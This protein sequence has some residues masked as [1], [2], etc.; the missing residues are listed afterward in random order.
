MAATKMPK[1]PGFLVTFAYYFLATLFLGSFLASRLLH[2]SL[3]TAIP[4]EL[5]ALAGLSVGIVGTALNRSE[6]IELPIASPKVFR[7]R[8]G[9]IL[10]EMGFTLVPDDESLGE[11][12]SSPDSPDSP[13]SQPDRAVAEAEPP[14]QCYRRSPSVLAFSALEVY[15]QVG[16]RSAYLMSRVST[17]RK[18]RQ[19]LGL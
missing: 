4:Y 2:L 7:N 8:L 14:V 1:G 19:K 6:V 5:A 10:Q 3:G 13:D 17:L 16:D 15:V 11:P 9:Q 12:L 18:I